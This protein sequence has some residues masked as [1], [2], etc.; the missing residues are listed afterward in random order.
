MDINM[1]EHSEQAADTSSSD[2]LN[3]AVFQGSTF[4]DDEESPTIPVVSFLDRLKR[5]QL[6]E[7]NRSTRLNRL[8]TH[9]ISISC[10]LT[11]MCWKCNCS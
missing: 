3:D 2:M 1:A 4:E 8:L 6:S 9:T 5:P 11:N 10:D 7:L